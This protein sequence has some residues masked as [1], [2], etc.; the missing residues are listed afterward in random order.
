MRLFWRLTTGFSLLF[1]VLALLPFVIPLDESGADPAALADSDGRFIDLAAGRVYL[2]EQG[3]AEGPPIVLVHGLFGGVHTWRQT[4]P[5]LS[6]AGYRAIA[7][8]RLGSGLSDKPTSADYS[9]PAQADQLAE[10]LDALRIE[11]AFVI[12][13]SAGGGVVAHFALRHPQRLLGLGFA[14]PALLSGGPPPF[15]GELVRLPSVE[16][17]ARLATRA[18]LTP[19]R[20]TTSVRA[21]YADPSAADEAVLSGYARTLQTPSWELGLIGLTRDSATNKLSI[22]Q[23]RQVGQANPT[24]LWGELD[25]AVPLSQS[26]ELL[27]LWPSAQRVVFPGLGHQPM[28]EDPKAFNAA[29]LA[30]LAER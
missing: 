16:R 5:A 23:L 14:A 18:L 21:F 26:D 9:Q 24:L 28:E 8:D 19:E 1:T 3:S 11:R 15:V 13:H 29:L 22:E 20:L 12:G 6:E 4:L 30:W 27:A 7:F 17:W 2:V 25:Q 10:L